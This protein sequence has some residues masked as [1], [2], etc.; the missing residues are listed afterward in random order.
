MAISTRI[1]KAAQ[2]K[3]GSFIRTKACPL[4]C[5]ERER[6]KEE[7]ADREGERERE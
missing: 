1:K 6:W 7:G 2:T 4:P 3:E 5:N